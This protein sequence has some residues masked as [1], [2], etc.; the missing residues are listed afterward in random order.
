MANYTKV[1]VAGATGN[2][3]PVVVAKLAEAGFHVTVLSRSGTFDSVQS[4][5]KVTKVDYHSQ[6]SVIA[7]LQGQDVLV[8]NLPNHGDQPKLIDAAIAAG[9]KRFIPSEF[10]SNVYGNDKT[11]ALPVFQGKKVTQ[12]YLK[13]MS[14]E[15]SWTVIINGAL[16]DWGIMVGFLVNA[17]G[18]PSREFDDGEAIR[19]MTTRADVGSAIVGVLNNPET[20]HNRAVYV[21]SASTSQHKLRDIALKLNPALQYQGVNVDSVEVE[22]QAYHS[23]ATGSPEQVE[24]AM[25]DFIAI[26]IFRD[27]YGSDWAQNNDNELLGI[28]E[29]SEKE[30][31]G[32]VAQYI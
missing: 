14:S 27:G 22:R 4:R 8:S 19:S 17:R 12:D 6:E 13:K 7:A 5:V 21:Q 10:G 24:S 2:L 1:A 3:G 16:L 29:L 32:V 20:T 25:L 28:Q 18:G 26:S 15:I 31:E 30:L 23:L 11:A 9:V